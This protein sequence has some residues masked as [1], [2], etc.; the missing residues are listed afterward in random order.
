MTSFASLVNLPMLV[1]GTA[2]LI[3]LIILAGLRRK[4][5]GPYYWAGSGLIVILL[6]VGWGF[7][8]SYFR[9]LFY[10]GGSIEDIIFRD[11]MADIVAYAVTVCL[12]LLIEKYRGAT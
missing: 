12:V 6:F 9:Y 2:G 4:S 1:I 3:L 8:S 11:A 10:V 5:R 7:L